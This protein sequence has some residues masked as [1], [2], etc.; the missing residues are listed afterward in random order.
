MG[1]QADGGPRAHEAGRTDAETVA[2]SNQS[3]GHKAMPWG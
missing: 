1:R 3:P 2:R